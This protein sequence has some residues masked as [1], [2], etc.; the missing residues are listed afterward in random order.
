MTFLDEVPGLG[1]LFS[2]TG[3]TRKRTELIIL[4]RPQIIR[5]SVDAHFVA[6]ELRT[7]LRGTIGAV[8]SG[9]PDATKFR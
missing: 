9:K 7:K 2:S 1:V 5:D 4:I 3:K 8:Q 6:E